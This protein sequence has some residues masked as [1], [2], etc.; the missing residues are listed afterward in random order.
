MVYPLPPKPVEPGREKPPA[1]SSGGNGGKRPSKQVIA[2]SAIGA[3][4]L[5]GGLIYLATRP[6]KLPLPQP[7]PIAAVTP[8]PATIDSYPLTKGL[9]ITP[10]VVV[11]RTAQPTA[12][13]RVA[14]L[15]P[16]ISATPIKE[17]MAR[18]ALDNALLVPDEYP[19]I[20]AAID[21]ARPG[22]TVRIKAGRYDEALQFKDGITLEGADAQGTV[23]QF[24]SPPTAVPGQ[25]HYQAP[26]EVRN[27]L[28]GTSAISPVAGAAGH[29]EGDRPRLQDR[30]HFDF[31]FQRHDRTMPGD[32]LG[33]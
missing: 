23:V 24:S 25:S 15:S 32:K 4:L 18:R 11:Q 5:V 22:D 17:Q 30:R 8:S 20:Q 31:Q 1:S 28:S 2:F 9:R 13:V 26:L 21:A 7:A 27:C 14:I 29:S 33:C 19:S 10:Q 6:S 12:S 3:V 16:S